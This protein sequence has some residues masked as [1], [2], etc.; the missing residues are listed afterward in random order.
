MSALWP[1]SQS[2]SVNKYHLRIGT[3]IFK[4]KEQQYLYSNLVKRH[5]IQVFSQTD[6]S[7]IEDFIKETKSQLLFSVH[8]FA[9][10]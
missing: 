6:K 10:M 4:T 9:K 5:H 3:D 1:L 8:S 7:H 2:L